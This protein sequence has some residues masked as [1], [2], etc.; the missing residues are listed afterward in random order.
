MPIRWHDNIPVLG[1]MLLR[2][3]CRDCGLAISWRYPVVEL[4]TAALFLACYA[5]FGLGWTTLK[6]CVFCFLIVG[7]IFMDAETGLL[8]AEFTYSGIALG[9]LFVW[10][11]PIDHAGSDFLRNA[12]NLRN[13]V[14]ERALSLGDAILAAIF[15]AGFF[16]VAWAIYFLIR[17]RQGLGFGDIAMIAMAGTFLG[18]KLTVLVVFFS[19]ILATLYV[20][21]LL[22]A[23]PTAGNI[24][25]ATDSDNDGSEEPFLLREVPFGVFL[26]VSSLLAVFLGQRIWSA[27]LASFR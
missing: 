14:S 19:P 23:R 27:Y 3:R 24:A 18:L 7:L 13:V 12:F 26:G 8:P 15:G 1:W 5:S 9:L 6:F 10:V 4:L 16:Y 2:G 22:F 11:V 21:S 17:K 25:P 20:I